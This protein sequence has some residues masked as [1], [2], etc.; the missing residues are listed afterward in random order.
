MLYEPLLGGRIYFFFGGGFGGFR[1]VGTLPFTF[2]EFPPGL[3]LG[4]DFGVEVTFFAIA[5]DF[6]ND[7]L[8]NIVLFP[9][10][11]YF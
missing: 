8:K 6:M 11:L 5:I 10:Q 3:F 2:T 7:R 4:T 9:N 1:I